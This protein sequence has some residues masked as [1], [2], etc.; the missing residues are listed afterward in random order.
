MPQWAFLQVTGNEI[1]EAVTARVQNIN[2]LKGSTH[3][4][5]GRSADRPACV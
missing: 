1:E 3:L 4:D 2:G 5:E